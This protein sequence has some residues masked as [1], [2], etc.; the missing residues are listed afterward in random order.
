MWLEILVIVGIYKYAKTKWKKQK[1]AD[2]AIATFGSNPN[3]DSERIHMFTFN[4]SDHDQL[5]YY[6]L[7]LCKVNQSEEWS[8]VK[9]EYQLSFNK[10]CETVTVFE[11]DESSQNK[12]NFCFK[13]FKKILYCSRTH[14]F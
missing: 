4:S 1:I 2:N 8:L 5:N 9:H 10:N 6:N 13:D 14:T 3:F 11:L 12:Q 7:N